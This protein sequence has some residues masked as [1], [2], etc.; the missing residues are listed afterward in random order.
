M[1]EHKSFRLILVLGFAL[2]FAGVVSAQVTPDK[3]LVVNG[4]TAEAGIRQIDGHSYIDIEALAQVTDAVI[5][6]QA[7]RIILT[8]P[9]AKPAAAPSA[10][11][12]QA[13]QPIQPAQGLS[14]EFASA[15]IS[16]V[17][18][19]RGWRGVVETMVTYGLAVSGTWA[20]DYHDQADGV[21]RQ[22]TLAATTDSDRSALQ[23]L[24]NEFDTLDGWTSDVQAARRVLNGAQTVD[25]NALANDPVLTKITN[26]SRFLN[27]M[28]VSGE[29]SDDGSC[30]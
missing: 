6:V 17:A 11:A 14:R 25:P 24:R 29:F 21:L 8:I 16:T 22:A 26:C 3:A 18:E 1:N 2:S 20:R 5:T 30:H 7:D 13:A 10:P 27:G 19:M 4:K 12:P 9:V 23:L 28:L 15:A